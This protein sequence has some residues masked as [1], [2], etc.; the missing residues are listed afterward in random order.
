MSDRLSLGLV[1]ALG[2][3][4]AHDDLRNVVAW[5]HENARRGRH[6]KRRSWHVDMG[7]LGCRHIMYGHGLLSCL[8]SFLEKKILEKGESRMEGGEQ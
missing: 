3:M 4:S 6:K 1:F 5:H 7:R 2:A 8:A